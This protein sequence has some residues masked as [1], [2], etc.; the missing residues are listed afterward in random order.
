MHEM[1][2]A[3]QVIE[4]A[5]ASIPPEL[6]DAKVERDTASDRKIFRSGGRKSDILFLS[7]CPKDAAVKG[8]RRLK[9]SRRLYAVAP[10]FFNGKWIWRHFHA[11]NAA[12]PTLI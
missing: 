6:K 1:G 9:K 12:V 10:A 7:G 5:T 3:L 8:L 2:I 4:V 11:R